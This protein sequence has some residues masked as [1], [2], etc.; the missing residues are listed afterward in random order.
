LVPLP[1]TERGIPLPPRG[2]GN[3]GTIDPAVV[4]H[5]SNEAAAYLHHLEAYFGVSIRRVAIDAPSDPRPN[6][7]TRRKAEEALDS[8]GISCF[9]TPSA[10]EFEG[11]RRKVQAHLQVGGAQSRFPHA[12]QLWMLVG[13]AL[14][15]RLRR[16]WE[17]LEVFP[18]ATIVVLDA[19]ATHKSK[20]G[21]VSAQLAAVAQFTGWPEPPIE[22]SL[23]V[24]CHGP[25]HDCLDAYLAAWMAA[26]SPEGRVPIGTPPDDVIWVPL[27]PCQY[28]TQSGTLRVS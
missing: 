28:L 16:D 12:N 5:F 18:Q 19:N 11:I 22:R 14:F 21:G 9:T 2:Q 6:N 23:K 8:R 4:A 10:I 20:P 1:L 15:E 7:L 26:L 27:L 25:T 17:C 24:V 13:F 3:I